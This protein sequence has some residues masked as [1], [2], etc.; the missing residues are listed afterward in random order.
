MAAGLATL[1]IG[2]MNLNKRVENL[3]LRWK[4]R[5]LE[6]IEV[7]LLSPAIVADRSLKCEGKRNIAKVGLLRD[8]YHEGILG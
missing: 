7:F 1:G 8:L 3:I 4:S 6:W 5:I 2:E